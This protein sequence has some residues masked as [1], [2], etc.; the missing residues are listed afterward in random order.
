MATPQRHAYG[1]LEHRDPLADHRL[2]GLLVLAGIYSLS[3]ST[4][5]L[6]LTFGS[7]VLL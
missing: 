5:D 2:G 1:L 4:F 6:I 3:K 7:P